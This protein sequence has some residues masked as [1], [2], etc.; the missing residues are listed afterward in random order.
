[1]S[2]A[3]NNT[4]IKIV[5]QAFFQNISLALK[6]SFV[7]ADGDDGITPRVERTFH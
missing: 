6:S 7:H 4:T 3:E 1:M 5:K 2:K